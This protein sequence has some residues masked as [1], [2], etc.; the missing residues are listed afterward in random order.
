MCNLSVKVGFYVPA[1]YFYRA[2]VI[3]DV[4]SCQLRYNLHVL[5]TNFHDDDDEHQPK[6][7]LRQMVY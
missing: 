4:V 5:L 1:T 7:H 6:S 3:H 2:V